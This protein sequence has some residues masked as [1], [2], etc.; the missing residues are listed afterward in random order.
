MSLSGADLGFVKILRLLRTLRPLRFISH[1]VNLRLVVTALFSSA[2]SLVNVVIVLIMIWLMFAILAINIVG[3]KM[4]RCDLDEY[5]GISYD[6]CIAMGENWVVPDVNFDNVVVGMLSL[7]ILSTQEGW[8]DIMNT[9]S[10]ANDKIY[11]PERNENSTF[12]YI[13]FII[14]IF[15][16]SYFL[17]NLFVGVLFMEY[18][19]AQ[20]EE[21]KL[22]EGLGLRIKQ[23]KHMQRLILKKKPDLSQVEP[24]YNWQKK[25]FKITSST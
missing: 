9:V 21:N 1:N 20:D 6:E 10:D 14:F 23:W 17:L 24:P 11:G 18:A 12:S 13:Y 19:K 8:P 22:D 2:T 5:Y 25:F 15:V 4:G 7:F 3:D 16:G